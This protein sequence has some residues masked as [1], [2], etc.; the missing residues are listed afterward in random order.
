MGASASTDSQASSS[1][2]A[3]EEKDILPILSCQLPKQ[4]SLSTETSRLL[5]AQ[6][7]VVLDSDPQHIIEVVA[8]RWRPL[9]FWMLNPAFLP[10]IQLVGRWGIAC[11]S[12]SQGADDPE[13]RQW[14][15]QYNQT[16]R[17]SVLRTLSGSSTEPTQQF[18]IE[19]PM[20]PT[21]EDALPLVMPFAHVVALLC[22]Q[23]L[24]IPPYDLS[25]TRPQGNVCPAVTL[26]G[27]TG[28]QILLHMVL[29]FVRAVLGIP[30]PE[31][32]FGENSSFEPDVQVSDPV[33]EFKAA[34]YELRNIFSGRKPDAQFNERETQA[35][36][37]AAEH[38]LERIF[39]AQDPGAVSCW[40]LRL[41]CWAVKVNWR[42]NMQ[43]CES[44]GTSETANGHPTCL[45]TIRS[46]LKGYTYQVDALLNTY[47][48]R[49]SQ[50]LPLD[51]WYR[52]FMAR[53]PDAP[54]Y[55]SSLDTAILK[56]VARCQRKRQQ[57]AS[58]SEV[59]DNR[60]LTAEDLDD[61]RQSLDH[62][63]SNDAARLGAPCY[64][65]RRINDFRF[66]SDPCTAAYTSATRDW[67]LLPTDSYHQE[68]DVTYNWV[69]TTEKWQALHKW[70][71][72]QDLKFANGDR[73]AE[74]QPSRE[75]E[76]CFMVLRV[77]PYVPLAAL[78]YDLSHFNE[79]EIVLPRG[80]AFTLKRVMT[81][82]PEDYKQRL[83]F[84]VD[85]SYPDRAPLKRKSDNET[86]EPSSKL[87]AW[88]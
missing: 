63:F 64:L 82:C 15:L 7:D 2:G 42:N 1:S 37:R 38:I 28:W 56:E 24:N 83:I 72:L 35:G 3:A 26:K 45:G 88:A 53:D 30:A 25:A 29:P 60:C 73:W 11:P 43:W 55:D 75:L 31:R 79:A 57:S 71:Q 87:A 21:M 52:L 17:A 10:L 77:A 74:L 50:T 78:G 44:M 85:V 58:P 16:I 47:L 62:F 18:G 54:P 13:F 22:D 80:L 49:G 70:W 84:F 27:I 12:Q 81:V 4:V 23:R 34:E 5:A 68:S 32:P 65:F 8:S 86:S 76:C 46:V 40:T 66:L 59:T 33:H 36:Y 14:M 41:A 51:V 20:P 6:Y 48:R 39:S 19:L 67:N 9:Q 69:D 61:L